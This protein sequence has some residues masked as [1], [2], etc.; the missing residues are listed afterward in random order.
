MVYPGLVKLLLVKIIFLFVIHIFLDVLWVTSTG[1]KT[2]L[3]QRLLHW[4]AIN[5]Y[6]SYII[7]CHVNKNNMASFEHYAHKYCTFRD[8]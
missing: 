8:K 7:S 1:C 3:E 2:L 6:L 5:N 4:L